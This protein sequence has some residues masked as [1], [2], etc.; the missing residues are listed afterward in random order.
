[1]KFRAST[2][3][4]YHGEFASAGPKNYGFRVSTGATKVKVRGISLT[5]RVRETLNW[6]SM[7][8]AI[9]NVLED[10]RAGLSPEEAA[11]EHV[12]HRKM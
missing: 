3:R 9:T 8:M 6:N 7:L 11:D 4:R 10:V 12:L 2:V 1:M 5:V